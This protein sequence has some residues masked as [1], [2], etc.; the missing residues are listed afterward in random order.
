MNTVYD[1]NDARVLISPLNFG[2]FHLRFSLPTPT[3][4]HWLLTVL[5]V[6]CLVSVR[7]YNWQQRHPQEPSWWKNNW[8]HHQ[9]TEY[10][11]LH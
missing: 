11:N 6:S 7:R 10:F 2:C 8:K 5:P 4:Y 9:N 3:I 1:A